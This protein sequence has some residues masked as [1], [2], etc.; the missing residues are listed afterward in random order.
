MVRR[1]RQS[2]A[3]RGRGPLVTT[4]RVYRLPRPSVSTRSGRRLLAVEDRRLRP[5][6]PV[7]TVRG[8]IPSVVVKRAAG[9][10]KRS[11]GPLL[12]SQLMFRPSA[13]TIVCIRR[14]TR[15]E[16]M[17]A[18]GKAGRKGQRRPRRNEWSSISCR[19]R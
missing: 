9:R 19:S 18:T 12:S 15:K 8:S 5:Q 16:V 10:V 14:Q 3:R 7:R 1:S 6:G 2:V 11:S 4:K 17:H 13:H